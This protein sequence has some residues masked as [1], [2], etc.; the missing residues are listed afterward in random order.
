MA[1]KAINDEFKQLRS[2]YDISP[3]Y[4]DKLKKLVNGDLVKLREE[5][6]AFKARKENTALKKLRPVKEKKVP[7]ST[8]ISVQGS[9]EIKAPD[10]IMGY[11][12][13]Y[14]YMRENITKS[15]YVLRKK[16]YTLKQ[17][18][19]D[20]EDLISE[21]MI[22]CLRKTRNGTNV[23]DKYIENPG[24]LETIRVFSNT[25]VKNHF[26]DYLK[27]PKHTTMVTSLDTPIPGSENLTL[28]DS[29]GSMDKDNISISELLQRCSDI[30]VSKRKDSETEVTLSD[31][32][33]KVVIGVPLTTVCHDLKVSSRVVQKRLLEA[34][35]E[36]ILGYKISEERRDKILGNC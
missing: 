28:A 11:D 9:Y 13:F 26:K 32:L 36:D 31:I 1:R 19:I 29:I 15:V 5:L 8:S 14:L 25:I 12:E 16:Y 10:H 23:Y 30:K 3:A 6:E 17:N 20:S 33:E 2:E 22:K 35:I 4:F 27:G 7:I 24:I 18:N 21:I 34:G